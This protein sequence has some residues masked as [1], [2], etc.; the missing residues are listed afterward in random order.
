LKTLSAA[1][2]WHWSLEELGARPTSRAFATG[3]ATVSDSARAGGVGSGDT[4]PANPVS[5]TTAAAASPAAACRTARPPCPCPVPES[6]RT[7]TGSGGGGCSRLA[8]RTRSLV[9]PA[10]TAGRGGAFRTRPGSGRGASVAAR[11]H[12]SISM[13]ATPAAT[14]GRA[15]SSRE[16][17]GYSCTSGHRPE[18]ATGISLA[19]PCRPQLK[20]STGISLAGGREEIR[21]EGFSGASTS[22][23]QARTRISQSAGPAFGWW[24]ARQILFATLLFAGG[25]LLL[26]ELMD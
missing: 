5:D 25:G 14:T 17:A 21:A 22:R 12:S 19:V 2:H 13:D 16:R 8:D 9:L 4:S 26:P 23:A 20:T 15:S 3:N 7:A 10:G 1:V 11:E 24:C 18:T 6:P